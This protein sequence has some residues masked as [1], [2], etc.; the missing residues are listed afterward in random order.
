[1]RVTPM[2]CAHCEEE[3]IQIR[4]TRR[5]ARILQKEIP[6]TGHIMQHI[7]SA[8]LRLLDPPK[9]EKRK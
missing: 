1:M 3:Y 6:V 9:E 4:L 8:L 7:N 5:E 2:R